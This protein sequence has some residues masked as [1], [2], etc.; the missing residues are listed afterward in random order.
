MFVFIFKS[1]NDD[2]VSCKKFEYS[3]RTRMKST[4]NMLAG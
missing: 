3:I 1:F 2:V 4:G